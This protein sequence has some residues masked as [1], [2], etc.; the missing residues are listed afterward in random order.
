[1]RKA[2]IFGISGQDGSLLAHYL[3]KLGYEV[4]GTSR[5]ALGLLQT[6]LEKLGINQD[7]K[8]SSAILSD[9][10]SVLQV[11]SKSCPD[12]IYNLA[13]QTS[14][15]LSFEQ[16]V[17]AFESITIGTI[18]ILEA[19]RYINPNIKFFNAG[20]SEC[21]GDV[22]DIP[23]DETSPF[24]PLSPYASAKAAAFWQVSTYR[25]A[26]NL[27][28]ST[29]ILSNHES[30]LRPKRFVTQK[31]VKTAKEIKS[32]TCR[33]L[34]LGNIDINRDW[35][36]SNDYV[37]AMHLSLQQE[38]FSDYI[39][40]TGITSSLLDFI[41][42]TFET[43]NLN[44]Q[45]YLRHDSSFDRPSDLKTSRLSPDKINSELSWKAKHDLRA[46]IYKMI[47]NIYD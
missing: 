26:Y 13:G 6:N 18:N 41:R 17:E 36:W 35:G 40:A 47:H 4:E 23:A 46:I 45:D 34:R 1:M 10:R 32:G 9:F 12:E 27:K 21:F 38:N 15:G 7:V 3:L 19:I 2:L 25:N 44:Y 5:D 22:G 31:I 30:I 37:E 42:I 11:I 43:L 28:C 29:G 8:I 14:V 20:S 24:N 16:P 33:E 39:I